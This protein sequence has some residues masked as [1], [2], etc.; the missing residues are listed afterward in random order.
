MLNIT[1]LA[2]GSDWSVAQFYPE[3]AGS[4]E[5]LDPGQ[6]IEKEIDLFL[7]EGYTENTD[8][9][10][11][12]ATQA[13]T[14]FRWLELPALDQPDL[15][16]SSKRSVLADPLAGMFAMM[17]GATVKTRALK[18]AAPVQPERRWTVAQVELRV[19]AK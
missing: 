8:I 5:P 4:F 6:S 9:I 2:L 19:L 17:T 16:A 7:L 10:K 15:L 13:T 3:Q 12:F 14:Q 1:V 11:V 18:L